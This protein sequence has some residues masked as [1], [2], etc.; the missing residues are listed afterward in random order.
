MARE[1]R[2]C[3]GIKFLLNKLRHEK[4]SVPEL[5]LFGVQ[6]GILG[7]EEADFIIQSFKESGPCFDDIRMA[8][9][10]AL[11]F[12]IKALLSLDG[13]TRDAFIRNILRSE[14]KAKLA[15][16]W[17]KAAKK[18]RFRLVK[19]NAELVYSIILRMAIR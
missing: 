9:I 11:I 2:K 6:K 5:C 4:A 10:D 1:L 18:C 3:F 7:Y 17:M 16:S 8:E 13:E 14:M 19:G 15:R 12:E